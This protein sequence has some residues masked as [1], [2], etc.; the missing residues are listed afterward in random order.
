MD[1]HLDDKDHFLL[2]E[3]QF[4]NPD[5]KEKGT[6]KYYFQKDK[7]FKTVEEFL[8]KEIYKI[9]VSYYAP[10]GVRSSMLHGGIIWPSL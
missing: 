5:S 7:I 3:E 10:N 4:E 9:R 2:V 6:K 8:E 1:A